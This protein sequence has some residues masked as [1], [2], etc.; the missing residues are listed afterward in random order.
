MFEYPEIKS[1]DFM[2]RL[3]TLKLPN[4]QRPYKWSVKNVSALL[5]DIE[6]AI[7]QADEYS[8]FK[9]RIGTII[10]HN[11]EAD[12]TLNIV[13]G[14][15]RLITLALI[16]K[17]LGLASE[18]PILKRKIESKISHDNIKRN[19]LEIKSYL[20]NLDLNTKKRYIKAMS[21][22][23]QFVVVSTKELAE[24]FQ[25]FDSQ[26]TRGKS[27]YPHD[28]LKAFH[29]REMRNH[30]KEMKQMQCTVEKWENT[31]QKEIRTLFQDYLFPIK[32]WVDREQ[33]HNFTSA[34]I[35]EYKGVGFDSPYSYAVRTLKG[36]PVFQIDQPFVSGK[37]FFEFV[38]HYTKSLSD[39]KEAAS[40]S[41]LNLFL[42]GGGVGFSYA[43]Q[44]F[45]CAVLYYYDRFGNFDNRIIKLLYAWAFM[46]RLRMQKLGFDT[47]KNY[48]VGEDENLTKLPMFYLLNKCMNNSDVYALKN[49][50]PMLPDEE[51]NYSSAKY[52]DLVL[53]STRNIL[54][55]D[56]RE[57]FI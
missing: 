52:K 42:N 44:L 55:L 40:N 25:L 57:D 16:Y 9:Y 51:I 30:P 1:V 5:G 36:M 2:L 33:G 24:A 3:K 37:N 6:F 50:I 56:Y 17:A 15:Q 8:K 23:L 14:Q 48:A 46:I 29:L 45:Y 21:S 54:M 35:D 26:N 34:D 11:N 19:F 27:L 47:V 43:Q 38:A 53:N 31:D 18:V 13:D 22:I 7:K 20:S 12:N 39:V 4:Y 41:G 10:L 49:R 28:L 32:C